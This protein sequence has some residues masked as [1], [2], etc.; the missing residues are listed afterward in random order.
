MAFNAV[1]C[2]IERGF[3]P[4]ARIGQTEAFASTPALFGKPKLGDSALPQ[5]LDRDQMQRIQL[6]RHLE[7]NIAVVLGSSSVGQSGPGGIACGD[8]NPCQVI[9]LLIQ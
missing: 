5:A 8:L 6:M 4:H 9:W 1:M 3:E 2:L 7:E